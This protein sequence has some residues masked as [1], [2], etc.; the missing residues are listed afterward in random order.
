MRARQSSA[1][2]R[3]PPVIVSD[4][5]GYEI[6]SRLVVAV[7]DY[8]DDLTSVLVRFRKRRV[9]EIPVIHDVSEGVADAV[10]VSKV[11][12]ILASAWE[13]AREDAEDAGGGGYVFEGISEE[14]GLRRS[15]FRKSIRVEVDSEGEAA[16]QSDT[17]DGQMMVVAAASVEKFA[18]I[19]AKSMQAQLDQ[20]DA[21][22]AGLSTLRGQLIEQ[23]KIM[24]DLDTDRRESDQ[25]RLEHEQAMARIEMLGQSLLAGFQ[26]LGPQIAARMAG[27]QGSPDGPKVSQVEDPVTPP[28]PGTPAPCA[29]AGAIQRALSRVP[30]LEGFR[31]MFSDAAWEFWEAAM[32]ASSR[33]A[34]DQAVVGLFLELGKTSAI[35]A[36]AECNR[37]MQGLPPDV[38]HTLGPVFQGIAQRLTFPLENDAPASQ[39]PPQ[40]PGTQAQGAD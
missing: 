36:L 28:P 40:E 10:E 29:E 5:E 22:M 32:A 13:S 20:H 37:W 19:A 16:E 39:P 21:Y 14:E 6:P 15:P 18:N 31:G 3:K 8:W 27:G 34:V 1:K 9:K 4:S 7:R 23:A 33:D 24:R 2:K 25:T 35:E 26:M 30:D 17:P 11:A 38:I 12:D